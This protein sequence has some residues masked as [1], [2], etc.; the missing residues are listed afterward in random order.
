VKQKD[1]PLGGQAVIN[2]MLAECYKMSRSMILQEPEID[3]SMMELKE[4]LVHVLTELDMILSIS[5]SDKSIDM[6]RLEVLQNTLDSIDSQQKDGKFLDENGN[7]PE[8]QAY[9]RFLLEASYDRVNDILLSLESDKIEKGAHDSIKELISQVQGFSK[10]AILMSKSKIEEIASTLSASLLHPKETLESASLKFLSLTRSG[11][12][13]LSKA[14]L[15]MEPISDELKPISEKLNSI[16]SSL[17][18]KRNTFNKGVTLGI[19]ASMKNELVVLQ[20]ELDQIDRSRIHGKFLSDKI[21]NGQYHLSSL[22]NECYCLLYELTNR[23]S[24]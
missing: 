3:P 23:V 15:Q 9:I 11:V 8:G 7:P 4:S 5:E 13:L 18:E 22:L 10:N 16:K 6:H 19:K 2:G 14:Y 12:S 20:S 24:D 17:L 1:P 21:K